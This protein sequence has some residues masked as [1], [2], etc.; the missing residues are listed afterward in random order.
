MKISIMSIIFL[1]VD[2]VSMAALPD[3]SAVNQR[4]QQSFEYTADQQGMSKQ[5]TEI[6]R[7]IRQAL[8]KDKS[9]STYAKNIKIIT[10]GGEVTLKGPVKTSREQTIILKR[11]QAVVGQSNVYNQTDIMNK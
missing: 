4:D 7:K 8:M 10:V 5:D 6:T 1:L 2:Q 9:L 3:N 11:A